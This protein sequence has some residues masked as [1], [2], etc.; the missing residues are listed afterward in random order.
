MYIE[1]FINFITQYILT[2][3]IFYIFIFLKFT[4]KASNAKVNLTHAFNIVGKV[5]NFRI[6]LI[7]VSLRLFI[8]VLQQLLVQL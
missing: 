8:I 2:N 6:S 4:L 5:W 3:D 7:F 1:S